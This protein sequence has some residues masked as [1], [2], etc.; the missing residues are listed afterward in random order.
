MK[1]KKKAPAVKNNRYNVKDFVNF[2]GKS[3]ENAGTFSFVIQNLVKLFWILI[4]NCLDVNLM[5]D[6]T[7]TP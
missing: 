3:K 7:A 6:L 4:K 1:R 5:A 2:K